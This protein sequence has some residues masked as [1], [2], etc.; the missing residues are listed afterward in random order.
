MGPFGRV[1]P[2]GTIWLYRAVWLCF[3]LRVVW[4]CGTGWSCGPFGLVGPSDH[5]GQSGQ[6]EPSSLVGL[7]GSIP[8]LKGWFVYLATY[9]GNRLS[10]LHGRFLVLIGSLNQ[11][12][13]P[14][15]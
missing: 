10:R 6:V 15:V 3:H 9:V 5:V 7:F 1:G 4:P 8:T 13:F 11:C 2:C 12:R 14:V